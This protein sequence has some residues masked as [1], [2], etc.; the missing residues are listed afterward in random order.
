M[1]GTD[2]ASAQITTSYKLFCRLLQRYSQGCLC[3]A[4][5]CTVLSVGPPTTQQLRSVACMVQGVCRPSITAPKLQQE[6]P[7]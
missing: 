3:W 5:P 4:L 2:D 1:A 7:H 6:V